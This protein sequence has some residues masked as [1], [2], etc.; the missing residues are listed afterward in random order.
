MKTLKFKT[1]VQTATWVEFEITGE[2][3]QQ[4]ANALDKLN[5]NGAN[6]ASS[7][8]G[9]KPTSSIDKVL[10]VPLVVQGDSKAPGLESP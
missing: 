9:L 6:L 8:Y 10:N 5:A 2:G 3:L 1:L 7:R 4:V